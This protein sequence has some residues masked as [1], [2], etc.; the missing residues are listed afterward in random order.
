MTWRVRDLMRPNLI[1]CP[2]GTPLSEAAALLARHRVP[3]LVVADRSGLQ[4]GVL[5]DVDLLTGEWLSQN[6]ADRAAVRGM[7]A[8]QLM[9]TPVATIDAEAPASEAAARLR[10][11]RVHRLVVTEHERGIGVISVADL[12]RMLMPGQVERQ[13][14]GQAMSPGLLVCRQDTS[15]GAAARAMTEHRTRALVVVDARGRPLGVVTGFDL[16]SYIIEGEGEAGA[17]VAA[18]MHAPITINPAA[19]LRAAADRMLQHHIHRLVV[20]DPA[21]PE[22]MPLGVVSSADIISAMAAAGPQWPTT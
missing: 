14:V 6:P 16:L 22:A 8:E 15:I 19:S 7:T 1:T 9:S 4:L 13:T 12:V 20:V 18:S 17:T 3:A 10:A 5:S 21:D 2:P 11:E